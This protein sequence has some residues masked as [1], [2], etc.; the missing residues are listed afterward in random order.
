MRENI[1]SQKNWASKKR[2]MRLYK[3]DD[4]ENTL[5]KC[6]CSCP[7]IVV[8]QVLNMCRAS[9]PRIS[10]IPYANVVEIK[11]DW[12]G[13][14]ILSSIEHHFPFTSGIFYSSSGISPPI[15]NV[16]FLDSPRSSAFEIRVSITRGR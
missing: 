6:S 9:G 14:L 12:S 10:S 2:N 16:Y 3:T 1:E 7:S 4:G 8:E 15:K 5:K 13:G 11:L